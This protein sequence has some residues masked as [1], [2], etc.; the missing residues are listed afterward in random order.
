MSLTLKVGGHWSTIVHSFVR[1]MMLV[2]HFPILLDFLYC[3]MFRGFV[4]DLFAVNTINIV[5]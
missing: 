4:F 3:S 2:A 5:D 1:M